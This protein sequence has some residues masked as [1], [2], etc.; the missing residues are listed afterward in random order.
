MKRNSILILA[1]ILL[2][3]ISC[4]K[5][6]QGTTALPED[7][8]SMGDGLKIAIVSDIHY[9]AASLLKNNAAAGTAFQAYLDQDPKLIEYSDPIFR[10]CISQIKSEKPDILL[11]PGDLTKDGEKVS[12]QA[13]VQFLKQISD[14][15][16]K[17][18]VVPG[19]HDVNNP[20]SA[21][22]DGDNATPAPSISASDFSHL[23][24][25]YGYANAISIDPNSLSYVAEVV[26]GIWILGLDAC[27]YENNTNIAI[28]GGRLKP[29]TRQW[30]V[31]WIT[32]AKKLHVQIFG[33]MHHGIVEHYT[34]QNQ[35][36]PGY[37]IDDY[38]SVVHD[39]TNAGLRIV[40]TGH[41][42]ANDI[43]S[44]QD[45]NNILYDIE[46]GS[47]VTAP[48]PYRIITIKGNAMH[49]T[50]NYITSISANLPGGLDFPT[51]SK[52]FLS[53][54]LDGYIG[55]AMSIPPYSLPQSLIDIGAPLLKDG[56]M[57]HFAGDEKISAGEQVQVNDFGD[58]VP[59]LG[60]G[61][62]SL[63]TDL[64]PADNQLDISLPIQ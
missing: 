30:A 51:Y 46:T 20:E 28:V 39:F 6:N 17:I 4:V 34:G 43:T 41:Y 54:H 42:H 48:S 52:E 18:F 38:E 14:A 7:H 13:M 63:W 45:G 27:N 19:N 5:Q 25:N 3:V 58:I 37:V 23:Y 62:N 9:M 56:F 22:Y 26:P 31:K 57:A 40:F 21:Q 53:G 2:S 33:M 16:I 64:A 10:Q 11:I 47:M 8:R 50:T 55:Y 61:I 35:L 24:A 44:R 49:I 32:E 15:H 29:E 59:P 60:D 1:F 36:D 12:H